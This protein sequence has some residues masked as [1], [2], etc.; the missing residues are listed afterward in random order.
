MLSNHS[1][2]R[3]EI[4]KT[5][6]DKANIYRN[7]K[8]KV[9]GQTKFIPKLIYE[10]QPCA[11]SKKT[12]ADNNQSDSN[13]QIGY[14]VTL[15]IAPEIDIKQGDLIDVNHFDKVKKYVAGEPFEYVT[16]QEVNLL[17]E[18]RA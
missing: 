16:H 9:N 11:L 15:F 12:L 5:Y 4:E 3:K 14:N 18:D 13:N 17:R 1:F 8:I 7:E 6:F 2:E 10:N